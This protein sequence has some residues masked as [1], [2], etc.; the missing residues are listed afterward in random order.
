[1]S[2][3]FSIDRSK[4]RIAEQLEAEQNYRTNRSIEEL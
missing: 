3:I 4:R 1:M 2:N